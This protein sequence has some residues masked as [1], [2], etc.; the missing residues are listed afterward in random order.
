M[1][2]SVVSGCYTAICICI[3]KLPVF[4][5]PYLAL[6]RR[7]LFFSSSLQRPSLPFLL[8]KQSLRL[9]AIFFLRCKPPPRLLQ[10][11]P[12]GPGVADVV[13]A[14]VAAVAHHGRHLRPV[15]VHLHLVLVRWDVVRQAEAQLPHFRSA[16]VA[17]QRRRD[18]DGVLAVVARVP[19]HGRHPQ[20]A[21]FHCSRA[22]HS[23][24]P[25]RFRGLVVGGLPR[26]SEHTRALHRRRVP[27]V[28]AVD[29]DEY[30]A[31]QEALVDQRFRQHRLHHRAA[32]DGHEL[33]PHRLTRGHQHLP[34]VV[35]WV[36]QR[37]LPA[38]RGGFRRVLK[39]L[40]A[41]H[42]RE[43]DGSRQRSQHERQLRHRE[44]ALGELGAVDGREHVPLPWGRE[45]GADVVHHGH[46]RLEVEAQ[47]QRL[48]HEQDTEAAPRL[49]RLLPRR[50]L[51]RRALHPKSQRPH[52]L[53]PRHEPLHEAQHVFGLLLAAVLGQ[54][55]PALDALRQV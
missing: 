37:P 7:V 30:V 28:L 19:V 10:V 53:V 41:V 20:H 17:R 48:R 14:L 6:F 13:V 38:R 46:P 2:R 47:P 32:A 26:L 35:F 55:L 45:H 1:W 16:I 11:D 25:A 39:R 31:G 12:Y 43:L 3:L 33:E 9:P 22:L 40:A 29:G 42:K 51:P 5:S 34:Q 54:Q 15:A 18:V 23:T 52:R 24:R 4:L 8:Y 44:S 36:L 27:D 21:E 50:H 49:R